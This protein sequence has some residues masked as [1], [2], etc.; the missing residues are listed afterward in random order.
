MEQ[1]MAK[2]EDLQLRTFHPV[3]WLFFVSDIQKK[4]LNGQKEELNGQ[5][6]RVKCQ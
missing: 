4:W 1:R 3:N 6:I 5:I 2:A